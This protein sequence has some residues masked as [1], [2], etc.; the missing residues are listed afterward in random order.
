VEPSIYEKINAGASEYN[1]TAR[2]EEMSSK[3]I[4]IEVVGKGKALAETD[5]RNPAIVEA[6]CQILPL[7]APASLWGEEVYF[8]LPLEINDENPSPD[9]TQGDVSYWSPGPAFCIFFGRTQP[10]SPV[11]HLGKVVKGLELFGKVKAGDRIMLRMF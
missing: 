7:E 9:A 1:R 11:N 2:G 10:Y 5:S 6:I 4:E 8:N 3:I